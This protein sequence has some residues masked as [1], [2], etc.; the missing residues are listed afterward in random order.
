MRHA[1]GIKEDEQ[2]LQFNINKYAYALEILK[3]FMHYACT[4]L[5]CSRDREANQVRSEGK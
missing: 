1:F 3:C 5:R 4:Y 2:N